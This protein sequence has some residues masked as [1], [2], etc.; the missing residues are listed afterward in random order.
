MILI[1]E[2]IN[3]IRILRSEKRRKQQEETDAR[4]QEIERLRA[5]LEELKRGEK[6]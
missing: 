2:V 5:E 6:R 3:I 1:Y 4:E